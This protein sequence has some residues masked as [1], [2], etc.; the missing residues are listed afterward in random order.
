MVLVGIFF[1]VVGFQTISDCSSGFSYVNCW[2][3]FE[4]SVDFHHDYS[5]SIAAFYAGSIMATLGAFILLGGTV[6]RLLE[7]LNRA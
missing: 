6:A 1:L 5:A 7:K 4:Q 2:T 3:P